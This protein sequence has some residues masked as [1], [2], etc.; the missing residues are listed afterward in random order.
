MKILHLLLAGGAALRLQS[1]NKWWCTSSIKSKY[2]KILCSLYMY[3]YLLIDR[4]YFQTKLN[5]SSPERFLT[6]IMQLNWCRWPI[7]RSNLCGILQREKICLWIPAK[8][9]C[10]CVQLQGHALLFILMKILTF[11]LSM[12]TKLAC[13][14][15]KFTLGFQ[16]KSSH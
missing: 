14:V 9:N 2:L 12:H 15:E 7:L 8:T 10:K 16:A 3:A 13:L 5:T 4:P 6:L 1:D 11:I